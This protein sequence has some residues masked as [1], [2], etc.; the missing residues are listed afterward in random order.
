MASSPGENPMIKTEAVP[1]KPVK[2]AS[3]THKPSSEEIAVRAHQIFTERGGEPGHDV[4]DWL[5]AEREL[6]LNGKS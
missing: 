5:R 3:T 6:S 1:V 2:E 4:E